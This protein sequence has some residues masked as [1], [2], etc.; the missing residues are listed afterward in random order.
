[1]TTTAGF[2][3]G[4][5]LH[6][7]ERVAARFVSASHGSGL[8]LRRLDVGRVE[9]PVCAGSVR[10]A[11]RCTCLEADGARVQTV[12][13]ALAALVGLGVVDAVVEVDGPEIPLLDGSAAPWVEAARAAGLA[14]SDRR[15]IVTRACTAGTAPRTLS[16]A[17]GPC[18][19]VLS[20]VDYEHAA[21]GRSGVRWTGEPED[22]VRRIAPARTFTLLEDV[23]VLRA[24]GRIR[25]GSLAAAVVLGPDGP[26]NPEGLRFPD[27]PARH[28]MLDLLGDLAVLG[29]APRGTVCA[30]RYGHGLGLVEKVADAVKEG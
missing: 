5:G 28:K 11:T 26:L 10:P 20:I 3:H 27:E 16:L 13:H 14:K 1:M 19:D 2:L 24:E 6:T 29:G 15:P 9:I 21:I 4:V 23:E 17:P 22:F 30:E 18:V 7:G 12:E 8:W 25:G